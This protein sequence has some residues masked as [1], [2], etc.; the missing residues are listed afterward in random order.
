MTVGSIILLLVSLF[1]L[2]G[3]FNVLFNIEIPGY[4]DLI[5]Q[6]F[7]LSGQGF[8]WRGMSVGLAVS[9]LGV[10][11]FNFPDVDARDWSGKM[12]KALLGLGGL[13]VLLG[14]IIGAFPIELASRLSG[15]DHAV[16]LGIVSWA[17]LGVLFSGFTMIVVAVLWA[18]W[19][20]R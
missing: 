3:V 2:L 20:G 15:S 8:T 17:Y 19:K 18:S 12:N 6:V 4:S 7:F 5:G 11:L 9:V 16:Q 13:A 10:L 14:V 1:Y